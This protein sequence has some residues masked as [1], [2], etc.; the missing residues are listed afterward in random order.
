[1]RAGVPDPGQLR[2]QEP[3]QPGRQTGRGYVQHQQARV[4]HHRTL[5]RHYLALPAR[6]LA[7]GEP[8]QALEVGKEREDPA[9]L[10]LEALPLHL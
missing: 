7:R 10:F 1:M 8:A 2:E 3:R 4:R 5:Q 6:E 9:P